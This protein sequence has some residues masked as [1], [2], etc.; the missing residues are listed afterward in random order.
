MEKPNPILPDINEV[1]EWRVCAE[2]PAY[3]VSSFGRVKNIKTKNILK[4][5]ANSERMYQLVHLRTGVPIK[6]GKYAYIHRLVAEAFCEKQ[7]DDQ[8]QID[9]IDR[10]RNNNYYKNLQWATRSE[11]L[12][13]KGKGHSE[14]VYRAKTPIVLLDKE[15]NELIAEYASPN[16]AGKELGLSPVQIVKNIHGR[17]LDFK[18][19]YF[20]TKKNFEKLNGET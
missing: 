3:E 5:R 16:E 14:Y 8:D 4:P 18:N 13:N 9:H 7:S 2:Y 6:N 17:R 11:N 10:R 19:G 15:T 12:Q 1:E 20:M